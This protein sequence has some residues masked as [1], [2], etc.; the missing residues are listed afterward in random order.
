MGALGLRQTRG[1][2]EFRPTR[3]RGGDFGVEL[4]KFAPVHPRTGGDSGGCTQTWSRAKTGGKPTMIVPVFGEI[5]RQIAGGRKRP[6]LGGFVVK[7]GVI[8]ALLISIPAGPDHA[9]P[10]SCPEPTNRSSGN[11]GQCR[12]AAQLAA[13]S[14]SGGLH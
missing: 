7:E 12:K 8:L 2:G 6:V 3:K 13:S 9:A 4:C 5:Q 11:A 14:A 1:L 10:A